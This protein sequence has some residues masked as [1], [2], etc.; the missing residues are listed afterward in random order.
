M[1]GQNMLD[2]V[3]GDLA[4]WIDDVATKVA[5]AFAP[6]RSPFSARVTED[7]KLEFYK[8]RLFNA[9]GSPN[10]QGRAE[11]AQRLGPEGL[12]HVYKA[13]VQRWPELKPPEAAPLEVPDEWPTAAP[14]P[15]PAGSVPPGPGGLPPG[16]LP[17]GPNPLAAM[18]AERR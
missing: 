9:D 7:Q 2:D 5:L 10:L 4:L 15:T 11:E 8:A 1:P 14:A 6:A 12:G 18:M 17:T 16:P 13:V 3:A